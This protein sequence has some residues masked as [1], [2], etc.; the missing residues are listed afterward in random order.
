MIL[1][2]QKLFGLMAVATLLAATGCSDT[3]LISN[4]GSAPPTR[5]NAIIEVETDHPTD[6]HTLD[7]GE[8]YA[9]ETQE[10]AGKVPAAACS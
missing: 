4:P 9:G 5:V 1:S 8:V 3:S 7:F 10:K 6:P 2:T